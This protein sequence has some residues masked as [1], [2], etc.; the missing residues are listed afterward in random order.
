MLRSATSTPPI[1]PDA[2]SASCVSSAW[3]PWIATIATTHLLAAGLA[4][5][6]LPEQAPLLPPPDPGTYTVIAVDTAQELADA[7]WNL[8][9]NQAIV[10]APGV[11]DLDAVDFPNGVDGR[12]TVG[13]FGAAPINNIQIRGATDDPA[14]VVLRGGG[15]LDP[16]VPYGFHVFTA[17]QVTIA[18]LSVGE[19]YFHAVGL[20]GAQGA[21]DIRLYRIRAFDTGQQ[22]VKGSGAGADDV[23]IEY[24]EFDYTVGA[25][26]HPQGSPPGSC[27]TNAIDATGGDRWVIRDNR[28]A[29]IRCQDGTLAGPAILMWQG[30]A[31]TLV[32]RN[33]I[34]D[35]SRGVALGLVAPSDHT[36]GIVRNN[37]I[38][39]NQAAAYA[40]DVPIYVTSPG[41]RVLHNT[42]LAR[43]RYPNAIE[44][45]FAGATGV[46]VAGNLLDA[47]I[48]PRNGATPTIGVNESG[49][50][51][52]WFADE[53]TG[54]LHLT[55]AASPALARVAWRADASDDFD[56]AQRRS[57]GNTELGAFESNPARVFRDGFE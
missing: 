9:S 11:Y 4:H 7:C 27:Y 14:D 46:E 45:R 10:I 31:D 8:A 32:E 38:R 23:R 18:Y 55:A 39:W 26:A 52:A 40:I 37:A 1:P 15:M 56:G 34:L 2:S 41:A 16:A 43:G 25:V 35:S 47:A 21:R 33:T 36:G 50:Q 44:V 28:I 49:A 17:R 30:S 42:V 12:L 54:D 20:D 6:R 19:V 57:A 13:R 51:P 48:L 22:L 5:A 24:S 53:A 3:V 29:R